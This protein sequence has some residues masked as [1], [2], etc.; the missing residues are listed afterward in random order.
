MARINENTGFPWNSAA[1]ATDPAMRLQMV[2]VFGTARSIGAKINDLAVPA[3]LAMVFAVSA[4]FTCPEMGGLT[5][6]PAVLDRMDEKGQGKLALHRQ[7]LHDPDFLSIACFAPLRDVFF[8]FSSLPAFAN[9]SADRHE[10]GRVSAF[11]VTLTGC[12]RAFPYFRAL[13]GVLPKES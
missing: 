10:T 6:F 1:I 9:A 11:N 13:T 3:T 7:P 2:R 4:F 8:S 12:H 5:E